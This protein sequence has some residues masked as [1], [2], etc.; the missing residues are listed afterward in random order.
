MCQQ[1]NLK[2]YISGQGNKNRITCY[3]TK[4]AIFVKLIT[5]ITGVNPLMRSNFH[6]EI[7]HKI[8]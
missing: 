1:K 2:E 5:F 3:K 6:K 7:I 8:F 4:T